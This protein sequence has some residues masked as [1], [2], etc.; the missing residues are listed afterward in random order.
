MTAAPRS[1]TSIPAM[2]TAPLGSMFPATESTTPASRNASPG[3]ARTTRASRTRPMMAISAP[4]RIRLRST[5]RWLRRIRRRT[6]TPGGPADE[7]HTTGF[8]RCHR[9]L[10]ATSCA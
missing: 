6:G 7:L 9:G 2:K 1:K 3:R 4:V 10:I 5:L 8:L